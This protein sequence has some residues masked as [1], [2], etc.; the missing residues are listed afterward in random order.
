MSERID[1]LAA[2]SETG[3]L[4]IW[5]CPECGWGMTR[6]PVVEDARCYNACG[7]LER[8][9]VVPEAFLRAQEHQ[10]RRLEG[11]LARVSRERDDWRHTYEEGKKALSAVRE[12]HRV[13]LRERD[14]A[15][16]LMRQ[17]VDQ[18]LAA[19]RERDGHR[20]LLDEARDESHRLMVR[21]TRA[22]RERDEALRMVAAHLDAAMQR[23]RERDEVR[24]ALRRIADGEWDD[25]PVPIAKAREI[26]A[27]A[28]SAEHGRG[29]G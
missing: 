17:A 14:E 9:V 19:E 10:G 15:R 8:A 24:E 12:R 6:E 22:E 20:E 1:S 27:F 26:A 18:L 23:K 25:D 5:R 21:A 2:A 3:R 13:V 4:T 16:R 11:E 29:D 28:L 7:P